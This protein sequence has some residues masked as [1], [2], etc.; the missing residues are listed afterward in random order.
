MKVLFCIQFAVTKRVRKISNDESITQIEKLPEPVYEVLQQLQKVAFDGLVKDKI[1]FTVKDLPVLCKYDPTCYGLLQS[2]EC[3]SVE[4]IGTPTQSFNF[5]HLGIQE[6]FSAKYISTLPEG[7]VYELLK[8]SFIVV[9]S[10]DDSNGKSIR[11]SNMWI[12]YCGIT[13]GQCKALRYYLTAYP[14]IYNPYWSPFLH[15]D[16]YRGC[17]DEINKMLSS[18]LDDYLTDPAL[19]P[20]STL[21]VTSQ[22][23]D[24]IQPSS[25]NH[26]P[27]YP[28]VTPL[29]Q[30]VCNKH[31]LTPLRSQHI[32]SYPHPHHLPTEYHPYQQQQVVKHP[33]HQP[34]MTNPL[35]TGQTGSHGPM[36][37]PMKM[38]RHTMTDFYSSHDK[39]FTSSASVDSHLLL[40]DH[41]TNEWSSDQ[42]IFNTETISPDILKEP[43][44][45]FYLFQCFQEA[46]DNVL[47]EVLSKSFNG[48][49]IYNHHS[50]LPYQVVSLGFFLSRSHSKYTKLNLQGCHIGDYGMSI[51]HQYL[52]GDKANK[53]EIKE[54]YL[55]LND[56]TGTSSYL[57]G[58]IINYLQPHTLQL[59]NN[60]ITKV[61]DMSTAVIT[62]STVKVL[63]MM[64]NDITAQEA[65]A[66]SD[67]MICL[68][69][70]NIGNNNLGNHG[71]KILSEGIMNTKTL[72]ILNI[73]HNHIGP[74]GTTSIANVL[75]NN[76][77]LEELYMDYNIVEAGAMAI[78][79]TITNNRALKILSLKGCDLDKKSAM[80]ILKS[81]HYNDSITEL[82]LPGQLC[83]H[84]VHE[85]VININDKRQH[86]DKQVLVISKEVSMC[87]Y[88]IK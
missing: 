22:R 66:I 85:E 84:I 52:S 1:V 2:T 4:E 44:K 43:V 41:T 3:Y 82:G 16:D 72:R 74:S 60:K 37:H 26:H 45:V 81:L 71:A 78:T 69:E 88:K 67:M 48:G 38:Y 73:S 77:S 47:C 55:N 58:E 17:S 61:K 68:E 39:M 23:F 51:L 34:L 75:T 30:P 65:V 40:S 50:L 70:L 49:V 19:F 32:T 14:K 11:F 79:K 36:P 25:I 15:H 29:T 5:L 46:Q 86:S 57:I 8:E 33:Y 87:T 7:E 56:L 64:F 13:S 59:E 31:P 27:F 53:K 12:L 62:T 63:H 35:L 9:D 83:N 21:N 42:R 10:G 6:Y 54:I 20:P 24:H 80:I 18:T 28:S 76:T